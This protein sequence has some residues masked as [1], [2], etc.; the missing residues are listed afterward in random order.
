M[1]P[2]AIL[3]LSLAAATTIPL[4][5]QAGIQTASSLAPTRQPT[6]L[7]LSKKAHTLAI[8]DPATL[9]VL[10]TVPVGNDPHEVIA[11]ADGATA[12][13][14]N[15]GFG[16][17]NTLAVVDLLHHTALPAI[18]LGAL[19]GPHGLTF[20]DGK[21]WFTA[22]QAK[23]IARYDPATHHVDWILGTGQNRT[24]MLFV[25][26]DLS[27]IVTANVNSATISL[28]EK[29]RMPPLGAG[30]PPPV[31]ESSALTVAA[32]SAPESSFHETTP[33]PPGPPPGPPQEDWSATVIPV[34]RGSEGFDLSP[35]MKEIWVANATDRTLSIIDV[36]S[37]R[38]VATLPDAIEHANR[39]KFTPDGRHVLVSSLGGTALTI[40]DTTTR[41]PI[42]QLNL[43]KG[44][45]GI[46]IEPNGRRAF[47]SCSPDNTVAVLDLTTL[48]VIGHIDAG[49][50]PDGLAWA[51]RP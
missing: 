32:G 3:A 8:V 16:A 44:A 49:G 51:T 6:L 9:K 31:H 13:V 14:S 18:D 45:A 46:L 33:P 36:A 28:F 10:A 25:A 30:G 35:D 34:G 2:R 47:I 48:E 23:A 37:K 1:L 43:G 7:V 20:V 42:K 17:Y 29:A 21:V 50:E 19:R 24:H 12:Y 41:Q 40:Y 15:Y 38:V 11:S 39:L 27:R 5:A 26:P 22:E 4:S